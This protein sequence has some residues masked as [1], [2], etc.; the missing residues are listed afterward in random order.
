MRNIVEQHVPNPIIDVVLLRSRVFLSANVSLILS[1]LALPAWAD[2][3][4]VDNWLPIKCI[5]RCPTP[6]SACCNKPSRTDFIRHLS[7]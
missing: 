3:Q 6:I 1:F 2:Q 5:Q 4:P 7:C